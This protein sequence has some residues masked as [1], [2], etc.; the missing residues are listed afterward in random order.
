MR[1]NESA[2]AID[3]ALRLG[4]T[5]SDPCVDERRELRVLAHQAGGRQPVEVIDGEAPPRARGEGSYYETKTG[6]RVNHPNAYRRAWEKPVY[7][8]S[9]ARVEVGRTWLVCWRQAGG[10]FDPKNAA[11]RVTAEIGGAS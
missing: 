11:E 6:I 3:A 5:V 9:T 7:V 4:D 8:C 1:S 10:V 2:R